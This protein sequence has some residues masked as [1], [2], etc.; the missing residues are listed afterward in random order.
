MPWEPLRPW[1]LVSAEGI[2]LGPPPWLGQLQGLSFCGGSGRGRRR[3]RGGWG[4]AAPRSGLRG[5]KH[6]WI[7]AV[8]LF[9]VEGLP[10]QCQVRAA[11]ALPGVAL[12]GPSPSDHRARPYLQALQR[13]TNDSLSVV[14][15]VDS[16]CLSGQANRRGAGDP[17]RLAVSV[18]ACAHVRARDALSA[19]L[20][21]VTSRFPK[22]AGNKHP[23]SSFL[24]ME[25]RC[26]EKRD[27]NPVTGSGG[28]GAWGAAER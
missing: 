11:G 16:P 17:G 3:A 6:I 9:A 8:S 26:K 4:T 20:V 1:G 23:N 2:R 27:S 19:V 5:R 28:K 24:R 14:D 15:G 12:A 25:F 22:R 13:K 18:D 21:V 7:F 10:G